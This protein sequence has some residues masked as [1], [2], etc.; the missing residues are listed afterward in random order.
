MHV[1]VFNYVPEL[2][3]RGDA[4]YTKYLDDLTEEL[5]A[6]QPT[7]WMIRASIKNA[8]QPFVADPDRD[9]SF[10]KLLD[11]DLR[12]LSC[13][14]A[15]HVFQLLPC[16]IEDISIHILPAIE[17][18][19]GGCCYAPGKFLLGIRCDE[20][21]PMRLKRNIAH[22]YS[23]TVRYAQE[24]LIDSPN[25][26]VFPSSKTMRGYLA[27]EGLAM[28]LGDS[29][30]PHP[31]FP[32]YEVS[33]ES[34]AA[35]WEKIDLDASG[36]DAYIRYMTKRAYEISSRIVS[37]YLAKHEISIVEAHSR[38]DKELY[39]KSGYPFIR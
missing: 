6:N 34:E 18:K 28:V 19:G 1:K 24:A 37:S 36:T 13:E 30:F 3:Q 27:Y 17:S 31:G 23:H 8:T 4:D 39:W 35:F 20:L 32:P 16:P 14:T 9:Q 22:E 29:L 7:Q 38:T 11:F 25:K 10:Q 12:Q 26:S 21:A 5:S 2:I 33:A 15:N